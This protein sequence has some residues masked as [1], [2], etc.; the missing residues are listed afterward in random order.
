VAGTRDHPR[1]TVLSFRHHIRNNLLGYTR[2]NNERYL[3]PNNRKSKNA[4]EEGIRQGSLLR[5]PNSISPQ[6]STGPTLVYSANTAPRTTVHSAINCSCDM[7][8]MEGSSLQSETIDPT[9]PETD[10][11]MGL[12]DIAAKCRALLLCR[13]Y[14]QGHND[15]TVTAAWM[16][17]WN[18]TGR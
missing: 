5:T 15:R 11:R 16:R 1:N 2:P 14:L 6:M 4:N 7:V 9:S 12:I 17:Y 13:M 8:Y 18:L 3:G 10:G